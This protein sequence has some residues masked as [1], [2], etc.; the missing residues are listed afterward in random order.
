VSR[1]RC[2]GHRVCEQRR[3]RELLWNRDR[4]VQNR[5]R[6][7]SKTVALSSAT[8][9][10]VTVQP[11]WVARLRHS[12]GEVVGGRMFFRTADLRSRGQVWPK[13]LRRGV[14]GPCG[15]SGPVS[16]GRIS[17]RDPVCCRGNCPR[18]SLHGVGHFLQSDAPA[19]FSDTIETW[20]AELAGQGGTAS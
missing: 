13:W 9:V 14:A 6:R 15:T 17:R 19:E 4:T 20:W 10:S 11:F 3:C 7:S 8:V 18:R 1:Q 2:I 16:R 5:C 12:F